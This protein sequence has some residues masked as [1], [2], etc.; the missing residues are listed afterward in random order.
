MTETVVNKLRL[1]N[2]TA[3]AV[4]EILKP[5]YR[6]IRKRAILSLFSLILVS[7]GVYASIGL[8]AAGIK[9]LL[10]SGVSQILIQRIIGAGV[11]IAGVIVLR[12]SRILFAKLFDNVFKG[13]KENENND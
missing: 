5:E 3:K 10:E 13:K 12:D 2:I 7:F 6:D 11:C 1:R 8:M 9:I 4:D